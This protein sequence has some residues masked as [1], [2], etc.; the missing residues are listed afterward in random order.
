MSSSTPLR[1]SFRFD[2]FI[3]GG[4]ED[5]WQLP[6]VTGSVVAGWL[7][8]RQYVGIPLPQDGDDAYVDWD[9]AH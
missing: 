4:D 5:R 6:S 2:A 3:R 9:D 1:V 7:R 8:V